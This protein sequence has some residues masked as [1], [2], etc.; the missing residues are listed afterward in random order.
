MVDMSETKRNDSARVLTLLLIVAVYFVPIVVISEALVGHARNS[1]H[2]VNRANDQRVF[3]ARTL[4]KSRELV[5]SVRIGL[6]EAQLDVLRADIRAA[7]ED[8]RWTH[9]GVIFGD[10]IMRMSGSTGTHAHDAINFESACFDA[11]SSPSG[12][13]SSPGCA[14]YDLGVMSQGLHAAVEE[15]TARALL[16]ASTNTSTIAAFPDMRFDDLDVLTTLGT[17][18]L[19]QAMRAV[20]DIY[21][22]AAV[23]SVRDF[24]HLRTGLT[25]TC[26]IGLVLLLIGVYLPFIQ[27]LSH[28][29]SRTRAMLLIIPISLIDSVKSIQQFIKTISI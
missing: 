5:H 15:F 18:Y 8:L 26:V 29:A 25:V 1:S 16:I 17:T 22:N 23:T 27:Q 24:S 14:T 3:M 4:A 12:T 6:P 2:A 28:D 11:A 10:P 13:P 7:V 21:I 9:H 19:D 20:G